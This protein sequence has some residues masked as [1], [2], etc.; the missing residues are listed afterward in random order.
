MLYKDRSWR[1]WGNDKSKGIIGD[2]E[3]VK[4]ISPASIHP[5]DIPLKLCNAFEHDRFKSMSVF[6][7][8]NSCRSLSRPVYVWALWDW[9]LSTRVISESMIY[10]Q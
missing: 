5:L 2:Y 8:R 6:P 9:M 7:E 1:E 3:A 4:L 10:E